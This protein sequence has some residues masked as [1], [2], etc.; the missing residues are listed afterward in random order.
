MIARLWK[1]WTPLS[2][3]D[4][5]ELLLRDHILPGIHRLAGFQGAY[6]LRQDG[7]TETEFVIVTLFNALDDVRAFAG[8]SYTTPVI[9]PEARALLSRFEN[10][11]SHYDI[12]L[13]PAD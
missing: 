3:G 13:S 2:N 11:A 1:G 10:F 8:D 5:Y 12:K 4:A 9:E 7:E 6:I